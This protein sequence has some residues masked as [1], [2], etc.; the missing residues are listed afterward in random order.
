MKGN[1]NWPIMIKDN[2]YWIEEC[3]KRKINHLKGVCH[4]CGKKAKAEVKICP[5]HIWGSI[6]GSGETQ[7][8]PDE[9]DPGPMCD[10]CMKKHDHTLRKGEVWI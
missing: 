10:D 3:E 9:T 2:K 7:I 5:F 4:V 1:H 6:G 8:I